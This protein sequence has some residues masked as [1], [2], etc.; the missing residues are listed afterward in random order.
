[1]DPT[2]ATNGMSRAANTAFFL[3][4]AFFLLKMVWLAFSIAPGIPPDELTHLER[5]RLF[6]DSL[7]MPAYKMPADYAVGDVV[8][9]PPLYYLL[10]GKLAWLTG[11]GHQG[12]VLLRTCNAVLIALMAWVALTWFRRLGTLLVAQ[13]FFLVVLTNTPMLTFLGASLSYDNLTILLATVSLFYVTA[14]L[15]SRKPTAFWASAAAVLAGCL[16]KTAFLPL[17]VLLLVILVWRLRGSNWQASSLRPATR[18]TVVLCALSAILL[19]GNL[20]LYGGNLV[21]YGTPFPTYDTVVGH[22]NAMQNRIFARQWIIR[23]Y[24]AHEISYQMA[25]QMAQAIPLQTDRSTTLRLIEAEHNRRERGETFSPVDR[26][27]YAWFWLGTVLLQITGVSAHAS[28]VKSGLGFG[29]YQLFFVAGIFALVRHLKGSDANGHAFE[30]LILFGSY[31]LFLMQYVNYGAYVSSHSASVA[32][33]GR[34]VF[35][36]LV[37]L[38]GLLSL[39]MMKPLSR[40]AQYALFAAVAALFIWGDIVYFV[41]TAGAVFFQGV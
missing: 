11:V 5:I 31:T 37:P 34:Y 41:S 10:M 14:F 32:L 20:A 22:K 24:Y 12:L 23:K 35:P 33:Q 19:A 7:F 25:A 6:A 9:S 8:A 17:A 4:L 21:R 27:S 36:V 39:Y 30:A 3:L 29:L 26:V 15:D 16:T 13:L 28:L 18:K 1:M 2:N 38:Y 40:T